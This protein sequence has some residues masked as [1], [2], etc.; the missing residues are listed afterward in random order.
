[1]QLNRGGMPG[2]VECVPQSAENLEQ[3]SEALAW[4][5]CCQGSVRLKF[6]LWGRMRRLS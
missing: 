6:G 4:P 3:P 5:A 1:M 2:E